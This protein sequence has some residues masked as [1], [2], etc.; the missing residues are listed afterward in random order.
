MADLKQTE[1]EIKD[2][3][4]RE[5]EELRNTYNDVVK[6]LRTEGERLQGDIRK[7]YKNARKYVKKNPETG[8]GVALAGGV[9]LGIVIANILKK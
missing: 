3:L 9:F 5:K 4:L 7:E 2:T 8:V 1:K 6:K